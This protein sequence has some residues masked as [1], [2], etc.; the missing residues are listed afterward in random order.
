MLAET[1]SDSS[2]TKRKIADKQVVKSINSITDDLFIAAG[3]N[4]KIIQRGD[5]LVI[6]A[7]QRTAQADGKKSDLSTT[8]C[9]TS[10]TVTSL[11]E[12]YGDL[13][14][15]VDGGA[16]I[17]KKDDHTLVIE[18]GRGNIKAIKST[19]SSL[20]IIDPYGKYT[21]INIREGGVS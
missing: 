6:S 3:E 20:V 2:I 7:V 21:K 9:T 17:Y 14:L 10:K 11:N 18:A 12:L 4:I 1:V 19:D 15:K 5:S 13:K 16:N 8:N